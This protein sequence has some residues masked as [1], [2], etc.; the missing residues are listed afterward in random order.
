MLAAD[1]IGDVS[2]SRPSVPYDV[3][4]SSPSRSDHDE[5]FVVDQAL[6]IPGVPVDA[7]TAMFAILGSVPSSAKSVSRMRS[8]LLTIES[9]AVAISNRAAE[10]TSLTKCGSEGVRRPGLRKKVGVK[11]I[12]KHEKT[13]LYCKTFPF[14]GKVKIKIPVSSAV[15][16]TAG[17]ST[18]ALFAHEIPEIKVNNDAAL[19]IS[20]SSPSRKGDRNAVLPIRSQFYLC[21]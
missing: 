2:S 19:T 8:K 21:M 3:Y 16:S 17:A 6:A 20:P 13:G 14:H 4:A 7:D 5:L 10:S 1:R 11:A 12:K 15:A 9:S 18:W